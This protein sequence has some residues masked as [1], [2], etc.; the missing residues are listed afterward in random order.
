MEN[1]EKKV[2]L[3]FTTQDLTTKRFY[4]K[5]WQAAEDAIPTKDPTTVRRSEL[6]FHTLKKIGTGKRVLDAG[7][8]RSIIQRGSGYRQ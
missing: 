6:L 4:E 1:G 8:G 3:Q 7:C 2:H 5:Y